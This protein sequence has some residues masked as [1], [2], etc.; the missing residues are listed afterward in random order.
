MITPPYLT[1]FDTVGI[2]STAKRVFPGE[3]AGPFPDN[4]ALILGRNVNITFNGTTVG[5]AFD[6]N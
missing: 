4:R 6:S 3:P 1:K 2:V 5:I